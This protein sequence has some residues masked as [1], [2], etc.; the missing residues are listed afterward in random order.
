MGLGL[1]SISDGSLPGKSVNK[2]IDLTSSESAIDNANFDINEMDKEVG[3]DIRKAVKKKREE[4]YKKSLKYKVHKFMTSPKTKKKVD[5]IVAKYANKAADKLNGYKAC[6]EQ[7]LDSA[8][9]QLEEAGNELKDS[10]ENFKNHIPFA[11]KFLSKASGKVVGHSTLD[12]KHQINKDSKRLD[13]CNSANIGPSSALDNAIMAAIASQMIENADC[14]D[15][16]GI[17]AMACTN[18]GLFSAIGVKSSMASKIIRQSSDKIN[19]T[20]KSMDK[21]SQ[22]KK[23]KKV[24]KIGFKHKKTIMKAFKHKDKSTSYAD[25][26][27]QS[28]DIF[29]HE[30][31]KD[32]ADLAKKSKKKTK[33]NTNVKGNDFFL[34]GAI[35]Q[36]TNTA[37]A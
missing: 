22:N 6:L 32:I 36:A 5:K 23:L 1:N 31:V 25:T 34:A 15:G 10:V 9:A 20:S 14:S 17:E 29:G 2:N 33:V 8:K 37:T 3:A 30:N 24:A 19:V 28:V 11:D 12:L 4:E 27:K 26:G 13:D 7:Q 18:N 21:I 16:K 35:K